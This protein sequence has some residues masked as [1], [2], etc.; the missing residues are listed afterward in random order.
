MRVVSAGGSRAAG[1]KRLR[2]GGARG[3]EAAVCEEAHCRMFYLKFI[4]GSLIK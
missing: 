1:G 4:S 2:L 3:R